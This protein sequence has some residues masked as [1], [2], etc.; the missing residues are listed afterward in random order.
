MEEFLVRFE[1]AELIPEHTMTETWGNTPE[2]RDMWLETALTRS[3]W[4]TVWIHFVEWGSDPN[5]KLQISESRFGSRHRA[6]PLALAVERAVPW[7][8]TESLKCIEILLR[9][10]ADLRW[11]S[12]YYE[13]DENGDVKNNKDILL[14]MFENISMSEKWVD[15]NL[16]VLALLLSHY[17]KDDNDLMGDI[18]TCMNEETL[19]RALDIAIMWGKHDTVYANRMCEKAVSMLLEVNIRTESRHGTLNLALRHILNPELCLKICE[20]L[21]LKGANVNQHTEKL[22]RADGRVLIREDLPLAAAAVRGNMELLNLLLFRPNIDPNVCVV[23]EA[24]M[25]K[26]SCL[27]FAAKYGLR[28]MVRLLLLHGADPFHRPNTSGKTVLDNIMALDAPAAELVLELF[29]AKRLRG[30]HG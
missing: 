2:R 20:W 19:Y 29:K 23:V 4:E 3:K 11:Q 27:F 15:L 28:E 12:A 25:G 5:R 18:G 21:C 16:S 22:V 26:V 17:Q 14:F 6:S 24:G 7:R 8:K 30:R 1:D 10:G 9:A 13:F